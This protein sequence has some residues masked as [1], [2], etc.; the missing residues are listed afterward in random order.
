[1]SS[2]HSVLDWLPAELAPV[3]LRLAR[4]DK[5]E[6]Q[7][8]WECL[9]WSLHALEMKQVRRADGLIDV[10]VE[11]VR[12]IPP[13][14]SMLFSEVINHLRAAID[15][16]VFHVVE[17]LRGA[18]LASKAASLVAMP[19]QKSDADLSAWSSRRE[20][21]VPELGTG[22]DLYNR[23]EKLQP[24][25][26]LAVATAISADF[27]PFVGTMNLHGVHPLTLLQRYSNDDKHRAIRLAAA[28]TI[29]SGQRPGHY[30]ITAEPVDAGFVIADGCD[31]T[32]REIDPRSAVHVQRPDSAIWVA[33]GMELA[34]IHTYVADVVIPTLVTG[35]LALPSLPR[36]LRLDDSGQT[37]DERIQAGGSEPADKRVGEEAWIRAQELERH[38]PQLLPPP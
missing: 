28:R 13:Q 31:G 34:Q 2:P 29:S 6:Y 3:A 7:L 23:I 26:S 27:E 11:R 24:Y 9:N 32:P 15:N 30:N 5:L 20:R 4:A 8:G 25:K 14:I 36:Q 16:V 1:V 12:P 17:S 22:T 21:A 33:P 18:P 19:I 37:V 38:P 10:V 35:A